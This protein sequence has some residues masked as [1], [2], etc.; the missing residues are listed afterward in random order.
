MINEHDTRLKL[1]VWK[2]SSFPF[3]FYCFLSEIFKN[4]S[5]FFRFCWEKTVVSYDF[6]R[7][8]TREIGARASKIDLYAHALRLTAAPLLRCMH[9]ELEIVNE[10]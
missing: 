3:P 5:I 1:R 8:F 10:S 9:N 7:I 4:V 6:L 2:V